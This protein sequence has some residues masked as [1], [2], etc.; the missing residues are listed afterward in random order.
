MAFQVFSSAFSEGGWIPELHSCQGADLSPPLEWSG[1]PTET[2]S[3]S[4]ILED[5]DAPGGAWCHWLLYDLE[6]KVSG[7]PQGS[8]PGK[9]GA[10]GTNDF[11]KSGYGGPC[12][13][14]G[15]PHRYFFTL[16]AL[17]VH[18]LGLPPGVKRA[19]LLKA[20][21]GHVLAEAKYMGKFQRR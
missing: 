15:E 12:P 2:L 18:T 9:L 21:H 17:D 5:P 6:P 11:G 20:I 16:S 1:A 7:L 14:K 19:E 13:P 4:L 8:K 3:F 10:G